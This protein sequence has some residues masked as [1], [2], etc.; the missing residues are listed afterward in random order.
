M[1]TIKKNNIKVYLGLLILGFITASCSSN[2]NNHR[3]VA[4]NAAVDV[5]SFVLTTGQISAPLTVPGQ[6]VP[7]NNVEL[8]AKENSYVKSINVDIGTRVKK[9]QLLVNLEA[10]EM[11][12]QYN[13]AQA[14]M[15]TK[16][17]T[18]KG[19]K[20]NYERLNRTSK[21][22]GTISPN[23]LDLALAKASADSAQWK[24]SQSSF[25]QAADL[26]N[27]LSIK[28]P[29]DGV[30]TVRN[31]SPGAYV[32]PGD[33][34]SGK[35][36]LVL[37]DQN[38][39]RLTMNITEGY[40]GYLN[41]RDTVGFSV[42]ALPGQKFVAHISRMAGGIDPQ[43][44]TEQV[45]MDVDNKDHVL[46][47]QM[48][49]D[50]SL[51]VKGDQHGFVI[52]RTALVTNAE[53]VFVISIVN[54]KAVWVDVKKGLE[55]GNTITVTGALKAGDVLVANATDEIRLGTPLRMATR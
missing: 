25:R 30:I 29:F 52:P 47:P 8:Y 46:L 10:P 19:S 41:N 53:R 45:E 37:Q 13:Q 28:A 9:G 17:A 23:D 38:R 4:V 34:S 48:Y 3:K 27:Y 16:L 6:L 18:Y 36:L 40:T 22:P 15:N 21:I 2:N 31:V 39:L 33:K 12:S 5:Q 55:D 49:A 51:Q 44:R 7:Y 11:I 24:A 26:L 43:T 54:H 20:A 42:R 35:P 32:G 14:D 50:I 1:K